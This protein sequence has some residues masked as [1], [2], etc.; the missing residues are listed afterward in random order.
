M[1]TL[2]TAI[3]V[4]QANMVT[5]SALFSIEHDVHRLASMVEKMGTA[6]MLAEISGRSRGNR[7]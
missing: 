7:Q 2:A 4:I 3:S 1:D 6:A 5:K